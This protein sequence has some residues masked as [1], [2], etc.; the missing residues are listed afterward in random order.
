MVVGREMMMMTTMMMVMVL[1]R[2]TWGEG[3]GGGG[4]FVERAVGLW[5]D[6]TGDEF[7]L[8]V[9][10]PIVFNFVICSSR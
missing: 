7:S 2:Q 8:D 9:S 3:G 10:V 5:I 6:A 1:V 4:G